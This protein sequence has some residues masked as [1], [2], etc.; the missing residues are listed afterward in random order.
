MYHST[1]GLRIVKKTQITLQ[2]PCSAFHAKR[3]R[4][5]ASKGNKK[6]S[7]RSGQNNV[8]SVV[9]LEFRVQGSWFGDGRVPDRASRTPFPSGAGSTPAKDLGLGSRVQG[10]GSGSRVLG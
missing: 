7:K 9:K 10:P 6:Y 1:L 5:F 2:A 3:K 8:E 4:A